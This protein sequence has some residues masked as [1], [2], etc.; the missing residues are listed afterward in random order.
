MNILIYIKSMSAALVLGIATIVAAV[1]RVLGDEPR[2]EGGDDRQGQA[3]REFEAGRFFR[4]VNDRTHRATPVESLRM[5]PGFRAELLYTVPLEKQ[6][7]WVCLASDPKGRLIA[8]A[9]S[10]GLYRITP[11]RIGGPASNTRVEP[12]DL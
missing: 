11:P 1:P 9:Q 10:G 5:R 6:G 12:V 8:S 4:D 7:S 3:V 2:R